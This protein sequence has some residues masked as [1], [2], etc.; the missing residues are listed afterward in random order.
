MKFRRK[1]HHRRYTLRGVKLRKKLYKTI[2]IR[3]EESITTLI[4]DIKSKL[5]QT[6]QKR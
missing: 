2:E 6:C 3:K 5:N 4:L 1:S